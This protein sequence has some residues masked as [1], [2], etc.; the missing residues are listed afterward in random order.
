MTLSSLIDCCKLVRHWAVLSQEF[1]Y[2][3]DAA[4]SLLLN[5]FV[6]NKLKTK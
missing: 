2:V 4:K 3:V 5:A 1:H 6:E